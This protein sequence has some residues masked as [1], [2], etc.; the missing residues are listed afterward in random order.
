M[1]NTRVWAIGGSGLGKSTLVNRIHRKYGYEI[2]DEAM[3]AAGED[4][5]DM[6]FFSVEL[7]FSLKYISRHIK[8]EYGFIHDR[9]VLDTMLWGMYPHHHIEPFEKLFDEM[10]LFNEQD[11]FIIAPT[12]RLEFYKANKSNWLDDP[13]RKSVY[14]KDFER[15]YKASVTDM[16]ILR[17]ARYK[18]KAIEN[19]SKLILAKTKAKVIQF[20]KNTFTDED[21]YTWE[22]EAVDQLGELLEIK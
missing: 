17:H 5:W 8:K 16:E 12:P 7:F 20:D 11:I 14:S 3:R 13:L 6:D 21:Y 2:V 15:I 18:S 9:S 1:K 22:T 19:H 4:V 10:G